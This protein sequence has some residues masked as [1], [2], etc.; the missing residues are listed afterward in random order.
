MAA[1]PVR[2]VGFDYTGVVSLLPE[3]DF[4]DQVAALA[5][6][7]RQTIAGAYMRYNRDFQLGQLEQTEL[8]HRV[9]ADLHIEDRFEQLWTKARE[10]LPRIDHAMLKFVDQLR[11]TGYRTGLLS[12]LAPRTPWHDQLYREGVHTHFDA[13]CLSGETGLAK[14]DPAAFEH[15]A[16]RL[17]VQPAELLFIDDRPTAF[18]GVEALGIRTITYVGLH[19]LQTDLKRAGLVY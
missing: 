19:Q 4:F 5:G 10:R 2:A 12:N 14:P 16:H 6:T 8:W 1:T 13:I 9:A 3:G 17:H 11:S 7:D 15:L 18:K